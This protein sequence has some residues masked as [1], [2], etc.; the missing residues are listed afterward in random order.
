MFSA[1]AS[2]PPCTILQLIQSADSVDFSGSQS[3]PEQ[4]PSTAQTTG[5]EWGGCQPPLQVDCFLFA[6]HLWGKTLLCLAAASEVFLTYSNEVPD[7]FRKKIF[8]KMVSE[9]SSEGIQG[10]NFSDSL[11]TLPLAGSIFFST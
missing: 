4:V 1:F 6:V 3:W 7:L 11:L 8:K 5:L 2:Y 10:I 9:L